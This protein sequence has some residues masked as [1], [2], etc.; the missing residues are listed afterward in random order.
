MA[1]RRHAANYARRNQRV[2]AVAMPALYLYRNGPVQTEGDC[3]VIAIA[4]AFRII[5]EQAKRLMVAHGMDATTYRGANCWP[6]VCKALGATPVL[7]DCP[8][9]VGDFESEKRAGAYMLLMYLRPNDRE[10]YHIVAATDGRVHGDFDRDCVLDCV[11]ELR[12][13]QGGTKPCK[14]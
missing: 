5:Y 4:H 8:R 2:A 11:Y 13:N 14:R 10:S 3:S 12:R 1:R 7:V 9:T 6:E